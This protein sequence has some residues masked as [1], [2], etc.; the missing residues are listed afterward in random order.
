MIMSIKK[1]AVLWSNVFFLVPLVIALSNHLYLYSLAILGV[2]VTSFL[3]HLRPTKEWRLLDRIA[4][5]ALIASNFVLFIVTTF[6]SLYFVAA[7]IFAAL[8]FYYFLKSEK[9]D[10]QLYHTYWHFYS[11]IITVCSVVAYIKY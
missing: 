11:A 1:N 5:V 3:Y 6:Y 8:A 4:A 2:T 10:G 7:I 9:Q